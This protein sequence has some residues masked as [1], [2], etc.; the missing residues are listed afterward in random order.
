MAAAADTG[1]GLA[2]RVAAYERALILAAL[3]ESGGS[4]AA[5]LEILD[6]PRRTLNEK[7]T[8]LGIDRSRLESSG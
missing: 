1:G 3:R 5:A 6:L 2:E 8:R 7:M 4:V